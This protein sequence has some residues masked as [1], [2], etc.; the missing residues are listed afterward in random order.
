MWTWYDAV[1]CFPIKHV[2]APF[3]VHQSQQLRLLQSRHTSSIEQYLKRSLP[4]FRQ[5]RAY[6]RQNG[7]RCCD[8]N[9]RHHRGWLLDWQEAR[10]PRLLD[11]P[12]F[13]PLGFL[14]RSSRCPQLPFPSCLVNHQAPI[15][16]S[17][18]HV[19][20]WRVSPCTP[21]KLENLN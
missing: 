9:R 5:L 19:L 15:Y 16:W 18:G 1:I 14:I 13:L 3:L 20:W 8:I 21:L 4:I 12:P 10:L 7:R 11:H 17:S 2:V 6:N